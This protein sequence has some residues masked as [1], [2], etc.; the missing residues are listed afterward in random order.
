M[1][2]VFSG[3]SKVVKRKSAVIYHLYI[4]CTLCLNEQ[5]DI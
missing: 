4:V 2:L 1:S 5:V 3:S